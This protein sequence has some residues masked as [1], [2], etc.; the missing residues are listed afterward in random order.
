MST[1]SRSLTISIVAALVVLPAAS[2]SVA[3]VTP[4][5]APST[6]WR[7]FHGQP[8]HRGLNRHETEIGPDNV[9][10]L[11]LSWVGYGTTPGEDL[12]FRSSPTVVDGVV[13][14]GTDHGELLAF[15]AD[16]ASENCSP[17][18]S[19]QLGEGIYNTP[20][21]IDGILYVGT[22]SPLGNMYAFDVDACAAGSCTPLWR[23]KMAV[24]SSSPTVSHGV[25]YAGSQQTGVYAFAA[26]G[27]GHA[28]CDPLWIG[29]TDGYVLNSPAVVDGVMYVG[30]ESGDFLAFDADGCGAATCQ[31]IWRA[32]LSGPVYDTS[33]VVWHGK[34]YVTSF[35]AFPNSFLYAFDA[36]GCGDA[37]CSPLWRGTGG[38]YLNSSP[39]IA[40]GNVYLG[41]GDGVMLAYKAK[42]CGHATCPP[43]R[44]YNA[45]GPGAT[46]ESPPMVA[47]GVVYVGENNNRVYAYPAHGCGSFDCD[48]LWEF[49]TQDPLVNSSPTMV[50]G[51]LYVTGSNFGGVAVLYVF[52]PFST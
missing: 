13:Y 10:Q 12:V 40:Y 14:F 35:D 52:E 48:E 22:A 26:D 8:N 30:S 51:T 20:A 24:G 25:V 28:R 32:H 44:S 36:D 50:N 31:P 3:E 23:S 1:R 41:S 37:V 2:P 19:I 33:P 11:S 18:W 4:A 15:P 9:R 27:C 21:V 34:V 43:I 47:N 6:D 16:C 46:V 42:G 38:S 29:D 7:Q 49:I 17:I 5:A 45:A 39:A